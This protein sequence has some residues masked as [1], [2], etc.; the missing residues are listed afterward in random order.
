[1]LRRKDR[2]S[3]LREACRIAVRDGDFALA[4]VEE[5]DSSTGMLRRLVG[6]TAC[7]SAEFFI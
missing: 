4:W 5:I 1:M 7:G 6:S 3:L 2:A